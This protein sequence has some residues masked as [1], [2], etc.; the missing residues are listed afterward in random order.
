MQ[1]RARQALLPVVRGL[2]GQQ[3]FPER[4]AK[5]LDARLITWLEPIYGFTRE[6]EL[7]ILDAAALSGGCMGGWARLAA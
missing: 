6:E 2:H 3:E 4:L 7:G 1:V 5:V